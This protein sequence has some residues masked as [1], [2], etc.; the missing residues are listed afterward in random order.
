MSAKKSTKTETTK[1]A[2]AYRKGSHVID[3]DFLAVPFVRP[4][5]RDEHA[6]DEAG[7]ACAWESFA[8]KCVSAPDT[9]I[10]WDGARVTKAAQANGIAQIKVSVTHVC[11]DEAQ[12]TLQALSLYLSANIDNT[13]AP[14]SYGDLRFAILQALHVKEYATMTGAKLARVLRPEGTYNGKRNP[15]EMAVSKVRKEFTLRKGQ[16]LTKAKTKVVKAEKRAAKL[17]KREAQVPSLTGDAAQGAKILSLLSAGDPEAIGV[18]ASMIEKIATPEA[19][20]AL[21]CQ[22]YLA[23]PDGLKADTAARLAA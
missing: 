3:V 23:L 2:K 4:S 12:A 20:A 11:K 22:L 9:L 6:Q 19:C 15:C 5:S 14:R 10:V 21:S 18:V 16:V 7:F 1:E 17:A 13:G 8:P